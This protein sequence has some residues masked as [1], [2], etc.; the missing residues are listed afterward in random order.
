MNYLKKI[1]FVIIGFGISGIASA[2]EISR[3]T[4]SFII[5]E[6]NNNPGG[7]WLLSNKNS[8]LQTAKKYYKFTNID[9]DKDVNNFPTRDD[10]LNYLNKVIVKYNLSNHVNYKSNIEIYTNNDESYKWYIKE[11][12]LNM[13]IITK[14]LIFCGGINQNP[15]IPNIPIITNLKNKN[16]IKIIHSNAFNKIENSFFETKKNIIIVGNGASC[17]DILNYLHNTKINHEIKVFYRNDKFY[18]PKY[19]YG[20]PCFFFLTKFLLNIFEY[21]PLT[22]NNFLLYLANALFIWN[23]NNLPNSKINSN[24]IIA[25]LIIQK[26]MRKQI[27]SYHKEKILQINKNL[28]IVK[29]NLG[30]WCNIDLVIF[31]TGYNKSNLIINNKLIQIDDLWEYAIPIKNDKIIYQNLAII[32]FAK[33]YNFPC[34]CQNRIKW[35]LK[36][37]KKNNNIDIKKEITLWCKKTKKRKKNNN[38]ELLDLTYEFYEYL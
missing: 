6:R 16:C 21:I 26:L 24:N 36:F 10:I 3:T 34:V 22:V 14:N 18:L 37:L 27:L 1:D 7:C 25:S 35:Y 2:I 20:I 9:F 15:R 8:S 30:I 13:H 31:A 38:L 5:F 12:N 28:N 33:S 23:L 4:R 32:G 29:T 11:K 19:I 17:C